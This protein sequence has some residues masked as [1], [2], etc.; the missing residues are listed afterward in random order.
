MEV[1][2]SE[3][4]QNIYLSKKNAIISKLDDSISFEEASAVIFD[5]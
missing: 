4:I 1:Q 2:D 5:E 3:H